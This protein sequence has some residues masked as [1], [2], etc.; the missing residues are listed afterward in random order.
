MPI[1]YDGMPESEPEK[2]LEEINQDELMGFIL[3]ATTDRYSLTYE[4][5]DAVLNAQE[6]FMAA[7]GFIDSE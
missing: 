3:R 5:V 6:Q 2:D 7:K 1:K 4:E